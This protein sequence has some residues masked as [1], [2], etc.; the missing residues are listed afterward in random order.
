[1]KS[2]FKLTT[3]AAFF[4]IASSSAVASVSS[5]SQFVNEDLGYKNAAD[6]SLPFVFEVSS[7]LMAHHHEPPPPP[8]PGHHHAPRSEERRV[9]KECL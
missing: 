5:V 4:I 3:I 6:A 8:P 2:C 1:M 9:G 7:G